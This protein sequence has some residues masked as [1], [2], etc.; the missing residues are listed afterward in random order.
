MS[1]RAFFQKTRHDRGCDPSHRDRRNSAIFAL[2]DGLLLRP[3]A[4]RDASNV[5]SI[6][7]RNSN[8]NLSSRRIG[9]ASPQSVVRCC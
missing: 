8:G 2:A 5:V 4:V 9:S 6:R 1:R 7:E 3:L